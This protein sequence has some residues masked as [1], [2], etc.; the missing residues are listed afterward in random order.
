MLETL[1]TS[2]TLFQISSAF[3]T[4]NT[5]IVE[6]IDNPYLFVQLIA[7]V[8]DEVEDR[9]LPSSDILS[10]GKIDKYIYYYSDLQGGVKENEKVS[11]LKNVLLKPD[12]RGKV[13]GMSI[14]QNSDKTALYKYKDKYYVAFRGSDLKDDKDI[15]SNVLNLGG[16]DLLNNPQFDKRIKTGKSYLDLAIIKSRQEGL[17]PPV[18]LGYSLGGVSALYLSTLYPNIETDL[19]SPVLSKDEL[20]EN[21]MDYLGNSNIHF[22]YNEKDPISKNMPYYQEKYPNLDINKFTNNKFYTPHSLGQY[23]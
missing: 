2:S 18:V 21:I 22:N 20:T 4:I 19:Y 6:M 9:N 15:L 1:N 12:D 10:R 11:I 7:L 8:Y 17:E 5:I 23:N 14:V 3:N 13:K 16:K